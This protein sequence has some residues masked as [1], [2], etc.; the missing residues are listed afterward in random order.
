MAIFT[1]GQ[2]GD[3]RDLKPSS[4]VLS[5]PLCKAQKEAS[6]CTLYTTHAKILACASCLISSSSSKWQCPHAAGW[7]QCPSCR[8]TGFRCAGQAKRKFKLVHARSEAVQERL[9]KRLQFIG[10]LG[11]SAS[12]STSQS[13]KHKKKNQ[14]KQPK[15][16]KTNE[17]SREA[18]IPKGECLTGRRPS[19]LEAQRANACLRLQGNRCNVGG[20]TE[21]NRRHS[22][23][24]GCSLSVSNPNRE[25]MPKCIS[26]VPGSCPTKGWSIDVYCE[27]CHG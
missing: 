22:G 26:R 7:M 13:R 2:N 27:A 3:G 19:F 6:R 5:C 25:K 17:G 8:E 20:V 11:S 15:T 4:F 18:S 1:R 23:N 9:L 12:N 10:P 14:K 24:L 16:K 21:T